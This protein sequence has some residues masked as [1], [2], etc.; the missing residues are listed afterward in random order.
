MWVITSINKILVCDSVHMLN[1][2]GKCGLCNKW[3]VESI[4]NVC[5]TEIV[6]Q[7]DF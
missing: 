5:L 1:Q 7:A 2:E 6:S 4:A 3:G